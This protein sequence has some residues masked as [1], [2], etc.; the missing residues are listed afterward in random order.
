MKSIIVLLALLVGAITA[1]AQEHVRFTIKNAGMSIEGSFTNFKSALS[2]DKANPANSSFSTEIQVKS[3]NT[4]ITMRGNHLKKADFFDLDK[5]PTIKFASTSV[6][7]AGANTLKVSGNLT[8][9]NVTKPVVL[10]VKVSEK[11]G[12][13]T[14]SAT[15]T[16]N[17]NTYGVGGSSWTMADDLTVN[18]KAVK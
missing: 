17:R 9:K 12:K 16:L 10:T 13:T 7:A 14:F 6:V 4:G 18:I 5:Y 8:I 1:N 2:Y 11:D 15:T 3:V